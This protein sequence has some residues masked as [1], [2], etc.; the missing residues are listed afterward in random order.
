MILRQ[1]H[2][3]SEM[4]EIIFIYP[5]EGGIKE[6]DTLFKP[7]KTEADVK[8]QQ[9]VQLTDVID[10]SVSQLATLPVQF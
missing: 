8:E 2:M 9:I 5:P 7:V 1:R 4:P 3:Y 6:I 10:N